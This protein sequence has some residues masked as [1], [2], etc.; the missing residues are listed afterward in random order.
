MV[1][2]AEECFIEKDYYGFKRAQRSIEI[3]F[4]E[5]KVKPDVILC[6]Y[7]N[8]VSHLIDG[9]SDRGIKVPGDVAIASWEDADVGKYCKTPVT[10]VYYPFF[11]I[12]Y[13]GC[14]KIVDLIEGTGTDVDTTIH[15]RMNIRNSCGCRRS[16]TAQNFAEAVSI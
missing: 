4:D 13:E 1:I 14:R 11:E 10:S 12:G 6:M 3:L 9:L 16:P 2:R 15:A 8:E 7:S 5:R